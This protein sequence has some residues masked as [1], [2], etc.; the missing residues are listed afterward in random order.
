MFNIG[1][2]QATTGAH[3]LA[4]QSFETAIGMDPYLAVAYFQSGVSNFLLGRYEA[5]RRDFEDTYS[6]S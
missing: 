1:I 5:A 3:D 6:V 2:I 4:V